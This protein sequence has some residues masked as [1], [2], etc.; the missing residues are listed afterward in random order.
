M[1]AMKATMPKELEDEGL[2][3]DSDE[4]DSVPSGLDDSDEDEDGAEEDAGEE[5]GD[6][7]DDE[8]VSKHKEGDEDD[9]EDDDVLS[10]IEASDAEDLL[11]LDADVPDGLIEYDGSDAGSDDEAEEWGGVTADGPTT[12][13]RKRSENEDRKSRRKKLRSLPTFASYEDYAKLIEDGPEDNI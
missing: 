6:D 5:V 4:D 1:Q 13:K 3:D 10:M 11:P 12:K 7:D 9:N 8:P 2:L